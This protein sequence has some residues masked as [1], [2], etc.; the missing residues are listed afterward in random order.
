MAQLRQ[1]FEKF[2]Q[3]NTV[4]VAIGPEKPEP[5]SAYFEEHD[6]PFRGIPDPDHRILRLYGQQIKLF[7]G[8][9]MPAQVIIDRAGMVRYVHYGK[10]MADIPGNDE[11]LRFLAEL[12]EEE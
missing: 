4:V 11:L 12:E 10:G 5:F 7:K 9:R 8:G 1:D 6:L 3:L 2:E